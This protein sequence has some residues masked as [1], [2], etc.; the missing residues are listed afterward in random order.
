[1]SVRRIIGS[2]T[3]YGISSKGGQYEN[4]VSLSFDVV[5]AFRHMQ[6][7]LSHVRWDYGSEDPVHDARGYHMPRAHVSSD[8][9]TDREEL[10]ATN[11]P[12][13]NGARVYVDHAHPEYSAPEVTTPR[14]ALLYNR[15]GDLLMQTAV[16]QFEQH[17]GRTLTLYRNNV[18]GKGASWGSHE[19]Y[20][21]KRS[22]PFDD[23]A[24]LFMTHAITRQIY[25]GSGRVGLG[26]KSE[27]PGFQLS[28]RADYVHTKIGLQTT[29]DRPIVNTRDESH[30]T[31]EFRRFHV[32]V[33]DANRMDMPELLKY[34]TTSLIFWAL[35][36]SC[37]RGLDYQRFLAAIH[38]SN[39]VDA[40]HRV[41][42][43]LS[44]KERQDMRAG[45][46]LSAFQLQLRLKTW[47]Y[48]VAAQ[49]YGTDSQGEPLWPDED[50]REIIRLWNQALQDVACIATADETA[51]LTLTEPAQRVEWFLKWQIMESMRRRK[52]TDWAHP[53]LQAMDISWAR[54]EDSS[55][56]QK[57]SARSQHLIS[58]EDI[59]HAAA[60][61]PQDTRAFM[62]GFVL[63]NYAPYVVSVSW[64]LIALREQAEDKAVIISIDNPSQH[65]QEDYS[66]T[67]TVQPSIKEVL[68]WLKNQDTHR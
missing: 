12:Q 11:A 34:G 35:E 40:L 7:E 60:H 64:D 39:P 54:L 26:K 21:V 14:Q 42:H 49:V 58:P 46:P 6:P 53:M 62:R 52:N 23:L 20:Q 56:W 38:L 2:E 43:D 1:M 24:G 48:E 16:T 45:E 68:D 22:V 65:T 67:F 30:S 3:E 28:Q 31:D 57:V 8:L 15:A 17:T 59:A 5:E 37:E 18:D 29:F 27:I 41:S 47:V 63:K 44:L 51:R 55:L 10:R 19:N 25:T 50:T 32:I 66:R 9:L 13:P 4:H 36:Q 61:P 33:G